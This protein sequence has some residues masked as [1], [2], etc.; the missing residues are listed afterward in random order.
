MSNIAFV[1]GL[2]RGG[3]TLV[4][5]ILYHAQNTFAIRKDNTTSESGLYVNS[6][7]PKS[8]IQKHINNN[9]N[10][11]VFEKTPIHTLH[12][13][14][15]VNDF[16]NCKKIIVDRFPL[17]TANSLRKVT[18]TEYSNERTKDEV[19]K[20]LQEIY[21]I[22]NYNYSYNI[23]FQDVVNNFNESV[24]KLYD[25]LQIPYTQSFVN[26]LKDKVLHKNILPLK[27]AF[28]SGKVHSWRTELNPYEISY[29]REAFGQEI[30]TF[31]NFWN[32]EN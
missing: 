2:P 14:E 22:R 11:L 15:I 4:W 10:K 18:W 20:Y 19:K 26:D 31:T 29:F 21:Q 7:S 1:F 8:E 23:R 12:H 6:S 3:T 17:A 16:P 30:D 25:F 9:P 24:S 32:Y 27:N 13:R 28:R 5:S